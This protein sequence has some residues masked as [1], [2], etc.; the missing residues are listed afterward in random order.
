MLFGC[1]TMTTL[2]LK[3][4]VDFRDTLN[5]VVRVEIELRPIG[6]R[7]EELPVWPDV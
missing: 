6:A 3:R 1:S 2:L 4:V 7:F 5:D